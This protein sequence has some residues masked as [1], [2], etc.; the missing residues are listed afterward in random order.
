MRIS[1]ELCQLRPVQGDPRSNADSI[2]DLLKRTESDVFVFPEMFLT[3]YGAEFDGMEDEIEHSIGIVSDVCRT[4]DKAVALGAPRF[5]HEGIYNSM[6]FLSPDGDIHYDKVHLARFGVY[7]EGGF[8][9]GSRPMMGSYH[10][11]E[12]GLCICYD[13]FFPEI[14]HGYALG[15]ASVN[16]CS[17]ASAVQ[18]KQFLDAVLPARALEN[19][20]YTAYVNNIGSMCGCEM[21]GCSRGL[22]P[23]GRTVIECGTSECTKT[24]QI[25]T[26]ELEKM[27]EIRRHL[28]DFR[29]DIEWGVQKF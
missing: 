26:E 13:V 4:E 7:S 24:L 3:G 29:S 19:V 14:L 27:R 11:I 1:V 9:P 2:I 20:T 15:G 8:V 16:I 10:G 22:D 17:A 25:D 28:I 23:F 21:H 6:F 5:S 18:S 12:F